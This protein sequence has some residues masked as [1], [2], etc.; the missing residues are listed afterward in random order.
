MYV[1][2]DEGMKISVYCKRLENVSTLQ[3][4]SYSNQITQS[5]PEATNTPKT[6]ITNYFI[7]RIQLK[8]VKSLKVIWSLGCL[9]SLSAQVII[10]VSE[11]QEIIVMR[12][13]GHI[14]YFHLKS[15]FH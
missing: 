3:C 15:V 6:E 2:M 1:S 13:A 5:L 11:L 9:S 12:G 14:T 4:S 8:T 10:L 7:H